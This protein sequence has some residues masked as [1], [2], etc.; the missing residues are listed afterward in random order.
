MRRLLVIILSLIALHT[1]AQSDEMARLREQIARYEADIKACNALIA[2]SKKDQ[3]SSESEL[4]IVRAQ[5]AKRREMVASLGKQVAAIENEIGSRRG[6]ISRLE[7]DLKTLRGEYADMVYAAWKNQKNNDFLLFLFSA[8]DFNAATRRADYM[9]RYNRA[10]QEKAAEITALSDNIRAK[11]SSLDATRA[12]LAATR[13]TQSSEA[14]SL[15]ADEKQYTTKVK[16]LTADQKKL[17]KQIAERQASQRKAQAQIDELIAAEVRR[18]QSAVLSD[19]EQRAFA[20]L[21]GR[22][23]QNR[24]KLPYPITGGVVID[25]F[26][27]HAHALTSTTTINNP[28]INIAGGGGAAVRCV[29]EGEVAI[30]G[31]NDRYYVMIVRHGSYFTVYG[32][33]VSTS[34]RIGAKVAAGQVLGRI[35]NSSNTDN[36]YLH[37]EIV[38]GT[39]RLNPELWLRR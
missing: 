11:V 9:R 31:S 37:F 10:R 21:S 16:Q 8:P 15:A 27:N 30:I 29:F 20:E 17:Q 24:G 39:T 19:A 26:G 5:L 3:T 32:N 4:K 18:A 13:K 22:F 1:H 2:K 33:L 34:V 25:K 23:D 35:D 6:D 38:N 12:E 28:G 14:T 36:N 7:R